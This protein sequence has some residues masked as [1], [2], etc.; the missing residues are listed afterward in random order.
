MED[1][2]QNIDSLLHRYLLLLDQYTTLRARL[3]SLQSSLFRDIARAN[4]SAERGLRYGQDHYDERMQAL[5]VLSTKEG[6][7]EDVPVFEVRRQDDEQE[8]E[9]QERKVDEERE[10]EEKEAE[11]G[12]GAEADEK[13]QEQTPAK[14][15][16]AT[17]KDPLRW[18]GLLTP[19]PLRSAQASSI[20]AVEQVI[21][22]LASINKE[23]AHIEIEIR[24]AKKKRAKAEAAAEKGS[25]PVAG[26]GKMGA[27]GIKAS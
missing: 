5:R 27:E 25:A 9:E 17:E 12:D 2:Q 13:E 19:Q 21:P 18:F 16:T 24:R 10:S 7:G 14:K 6:D 8:V 22:Q 4:F 11:E 26:G 3:S 20:E 23:M 15:P 1:H